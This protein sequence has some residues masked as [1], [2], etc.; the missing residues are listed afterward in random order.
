MDHMKRQFCMFRARTFDVNSACHPPRSTA[1]FVDLS[2]SFCILNEDFVR[3]IQSN[4]V[5]APSSPPPPPPPPSVSSSFYVKII[6][7]K[8]SANFFFIS[9]SFS[10]LF[11]SWNERRNEKNLLHMYIKHKHTRKRSKLKKNCS[12]VSPPLRFFRNQFLVKFFLS[13][14]WQLAEHTQKSNPAELSFF[15]LVFNFLVNW[16]V[17]AF[18]NT[19]W[20]GKHFP[21][22]SLSVCLRRLNFCVVNSSFHPPLQPLTRLSETRSKKRI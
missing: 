15:L 22:A 11:S 12:K 20:R 9:D 7:S 8:I 16:C 2:R 18:T 6:R 14:Y 10:S 13:S 3:H 17:K 21:V 19:S 1:V 5:A 4:P